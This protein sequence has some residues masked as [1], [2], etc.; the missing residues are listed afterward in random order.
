MESIKRSEI[1]KKIGVAVSKM[2]A[3]NVQKMKKV[4][5]MDGT[6]VEACFY[7]GITT[8]TYYN[9]IKKKPELFYEFEACRQA[10][11]FKARQEVV[12]GLEGD[13]YFAFQYLKSKRSSE[14]NA[15]EVR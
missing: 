4:F 9:W 2:T 5:S 3:D 12:K 14:F 1:N 7:T 6:V 8:P 15:K 11:I 10:L 13:P